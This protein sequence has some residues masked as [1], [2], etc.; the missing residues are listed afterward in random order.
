MRLA[1]LI[2][3][4]VLC[5]A[6][7]G[8]AAA[9]NPA[10][11]K[12][13]GN[14]VSFTMSY[15]ISAAPGTNRVRLV[16]VVPRTLAGRQKIAKINYSLE[17]SRKFDEDGNSYAEF[18][19]TGPLGATE[20]TITVDAEIFR[21]DLS[22]ASTNK[23]RRTFESKTALAKW[24]VHEQYLEKDAPE[25][26][27]IA[28]TLLGT[29]EEE[30]IRKTMVFVV[31]TLRNAIPPF[32]NRGAKWALEKKQGNHVDFADLFVALCRANNLP[33]RFRQG[34]V[35]PDMP[36]ENARMHAWA[37]VHLGK[38]GWVPFDPFLVHQRLARVAKLPPVYIYLNDHRRDAVLN[39]Y[40]Y[41]MYQYWGDPIQVRS[42]SE[43]KSRKA[44]VSR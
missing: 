10:I 24:L 35:I 38:Y 40:H 2:A 33:T 42:W 21:Y 16:V 32:P 3:F 37:E 23:S 36:A 34:R 11:S 7:S 28:K 30:T 26:Q 8:A 29:S 18:L 20:I 19:F 31:G 4:I 6:L 25:I 44:I 39:N 22:V 12:P 1:G 5:C 13:N 15:R 17:P 9:P 41:Y 43:L 14:F 27:E